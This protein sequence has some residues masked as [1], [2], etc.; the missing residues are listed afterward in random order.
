MVGE[1]TRT[2]LHRSTFRGVETQIYQSR[3]IE[4]SA[5][6]TMHLDEVYKPND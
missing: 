5:E 4:S 6:G 1:G 2:D 3:G